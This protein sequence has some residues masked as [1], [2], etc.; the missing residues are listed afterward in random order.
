LFELD[1]EKVENSPFTSEMKFLLFSI[2]DYNKEHYGGELYVS[3]DKE[4]KE[5][6]YNTQ[7]KRMKE[8]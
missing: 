3:Y 7:I 2:D 1:V 4:K 5:V 6:I 8:N